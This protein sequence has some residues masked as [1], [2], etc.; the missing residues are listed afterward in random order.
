MSQDCSVCWQPYNKSKRSKVV[1]GKCQVEVCKECVRRY[2]L[3]SIKNAHCMECKEE[4]DRDFLVENLNK[5]FVSGDYKV[6]RANVL[7]ERE[8]ARFPETMPVVEREIKVKKLR[9]DQDKLMTLIDLKRAELHMLEQQHRRIQNKITFTISGGSGEEKKQH[10][11][12]ACPVE[13]CKGFLSRAHKCGLCNI[14][15]CPKCFE[16]ISSRYS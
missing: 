4:W 9:E 10:F 16:I 5:S 3:G 14:W 13:N 8:K 11:H 15:A 2:L 6:H 7:M 1:C 12:R